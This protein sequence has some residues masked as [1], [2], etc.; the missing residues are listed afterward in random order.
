MKRV[1]KF[2]KEPLVWL[3]LLP[4][5]LF[6]CGNDQPTVHSLIGSTFNS[7]KNEGDLVSIYFDDEIRCSITIIKNDS[8]ERRNDFEY[9]LFEDV[10]RIHYGKRI[11]DSTK[12]G[13]LFLSGRYDAKH[14]TIILDSGEELCKP[15]STVNS[16][17]NPLFGHTYVAQRNDGSILSVSFMD[18]GHYCQVKTSTNDNYENYTNFEYLLIDN[19]L[20]IFYGKRIED[21][22]K[23]GKVFLSGKY[24]AKSKN[25]I[26]DSGEI[27]VRQK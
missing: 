22:T 16:D 4:I 27:M 21:S 9:M 6:S 26:L 15:S 7:T 10:I 20:K 5:F 13:K 24:D 18:Y 1:L 2:T 23:A 17:N 19:N 11:E 14:E 25:I 12:A 8:V 3:L